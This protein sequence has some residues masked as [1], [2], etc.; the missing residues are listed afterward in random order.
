MQQF[1]DPEA[2]KV[3]YLD[4]KNGPAVAMNGGK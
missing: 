3:V 1:T 2:Q 4:S